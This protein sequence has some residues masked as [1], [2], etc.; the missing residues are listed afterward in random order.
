M[1]VFLGSSSAFY[2]TRASGHPCP[3]V[4]P[5]K[6]EMT[7]IALKRLMTEYRGI[8]SMKNFIFMLSL[9]QELQKNPVEGIT[10]GPINENNYFAWE[11]MVAGPIGTPYEGGLFQAVLNFPKDYPLSPPTMR[12]QC[13]MFHPNSIKQSTCSNHTFLDHSILGWKGVYFDFAPT[14]RRPTSIRK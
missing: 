7:S 4:S 3:V 14:R 5:K 13:E 12:F 6:P 2:S 1:L 11:A 10:A 8:Y 9:H